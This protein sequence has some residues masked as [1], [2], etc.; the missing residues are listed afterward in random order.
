MQSAALT[1]AASCELCG[2][3]LDAGAPQAPPRFCCPGCA[4][5]AEILAASGFR[6]DPK[7]SRAYAEALRAGLLPTDG[8]ASPA[9]LDPE[10]PAAPPGSARRLEQERFSLD[11]LWC[12]SCAWLIETVLAAMPGVHSARVG[13][14]NDLAEV[15]FDPA[16]VGVDQLV[17]RIAQLGYRARSEAGPP[18]DGVLLIRFGIGAVL[19]MNVMMLSYAFY[20]R[21]AGAEAAAVMRLM[22]WILTALAAPVVFGVGWPILWRGWRAAVERVPTMDTLVATASLSA[23]GFSV[24]AA[25]RG[26]GDV[27]FDVA[28]A[29]PTFWVLGKLIEQRAFRQAGYAAAA[30]RRLLPRKARLLDAGETRWVSTDTLCVG[31]RIRVAP[32]ERVP[33]DGRVA[34]GRGSVQTAVVDGEPRAR[35]VD[36]GSPVSGGAVCGPTALD[37]EVTAPADASLLARIAEHVARASG[38]DGAE[39]L[40][41]NA[42][43][44]LALPAVLLLAAV[45]AAAW[46]VAGA[47]LATAFSRGLAVL[48]V[49][50][51]CSLAVAAPLARVVAAAALSRRGIVARGEGALGGLARATCIVFDKTGTLTGGA[52]RLEA[53]AVEGASQDTAIAV[54]AALEERAG[55]PIA[56]AARA[57][58]MGAAHPWVRDLTVVPSCGVSGRIGTGRALAGRPDWV[59]SECGA[60]PPALRD[61]VQSQQQSGRTVTLLHWGAGAWAAFGFGDPLRA[62]AAA[63]LRELARQGLQTVILSGD[64]QAAADRVAA[65]TGAVVARGGLRPQDKAAWLAQQERE[66][67]VRPVFVGD[68]INDAPALAAAIGVAVAAGTDFARE[69]AAILLIEN[70]LEAVLFLIAKAR[71]MKRVIHQNLAWSAVYNLI[72]IPLALFGELTPVIAAAL[73]V[74]SSVVVTLNT[75]RLRR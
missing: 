16:V 20:A 3:R 44:R 39:D 55:H 23:F 49:S 63:T 69:T 50:C 47:D 68:G 42:L 1:L 51:P 41:I 26:L 59:E 12:P 40:V 24:A 58:A 52:L 74:S 43:A 28:A 21:G 54:L 35:P 27:Y 34:A 6:G 17:R 29:L 4:R 57:A 36:T 70:S 5:V 75:L 53:T 19:T 37:I 38:R 72:A 31:H 45:S 62:E 9:A 73:M 66:S 60:P 46:L 65:A 8:S 7:Q 14:I 25:A 18:R 10:V 67:G 56:E 61:F 71:Q 2:G 32:G 48:V 64:A 33:V 11:G 15:Q 13:F 22:P 30:V